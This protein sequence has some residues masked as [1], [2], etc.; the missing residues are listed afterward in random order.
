VSTTDDP[1]ST[2][3]DAN[4]VDP[5]MLDEVEQ[6]LNALQDGG[7]PADG[8]TG[9]DPRP[10][11]GGSHPM[12]GI[13]HAEPGPGGGVVSPM[14]GIPHAE[15]GP[16]GIAYPMGGIPHAEPDPGA[17]GSPHEGIPMAA[18]SGPD[19]GIGNYFDSD[20]P[21]RTSDRRPSDFD[22]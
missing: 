9:E 19:G 10:N 16:G 11:V 14:G 21:V 2:Q 1:D 22:G 12:G 3:P 15:P 20:E 6:A 4:A 8:G 18:T 5:V 17:A 7:E 13:P